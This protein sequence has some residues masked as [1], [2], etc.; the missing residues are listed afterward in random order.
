M[1]TSA[2][3]I[4]PPKTSVP[5]ALRLRVPAPSAMTSGA[6]PKMKAK[7]VII[8]GR[9]RCARDRGLENRLA[10]SA[11]FAH[12]AVLNLTQV[13]YKGGNP[14]WYGLVGPPTQIL[15]KLSAAVITAAHTGAVTGSSPT[16]AA[17]L[18]PAH[19]KSSGTSGRPSARAT[20]R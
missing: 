13:A 11:L 16:R 7:L 8:T 5:T 4:M 9:K 3:A 6:R 17:M 10:R 14:A 19:R 12:M 18:S 15:E 20:H 2:A 1:P